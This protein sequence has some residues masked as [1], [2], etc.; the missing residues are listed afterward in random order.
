MQPDEVTAMLALVGAGIGFVIGTA[1]LAILQVGAPGGFHWDVDIPFGMMFGGTFG[2]LV[3]GIGAPLLSWF[4]MRDVPIGRAIAW[5]SMATIAGAAIGWF[6]S[7]HPAIGGCAGF[8][9]GAVLLR[10]TH[11]DALTREMRRLSRIDEETRIDGRPT[12]GQG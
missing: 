5:C 12:A 7:G 3:G 1:T 11:P 9:V 10:L 2:A 4:L 8:A 6:G